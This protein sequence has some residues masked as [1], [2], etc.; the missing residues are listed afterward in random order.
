MASDYDSDGAPIGG[1]PN[2]IPHENRFRSLIPASDESHLRQSYNIPDSVTLHFQEPGQLF[3]AGG[4]VTITERMLMAGF[5]FPFTGIARE[6]LV[7][8][9]VAPSQVKPNGWRYLFASFV[10]WRTKLQKKM[11]IAEFL[12]I[13]WAGFWRDST[14]E[15]TVRKKP[16]FIHL[17]WRYSNNKEWK[18]QIFIVSGQWERVETSTSLDQRVPRHWARMRVGATEA[19]ELTDEQ[20]GNVEAMLAFA[21]ATPAEEASVVLDFNHLMTNE[22]MRN[23]L[24]Y[25]IP[26]SDLPFL[27]VRKGKS[28]KP[29]E[30]PVPATQKGKEKVP[31]GPKKSKEHEKAPKTVKKLLADAQWIGAE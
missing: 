18:E 8:L 26:I 25:D 23:I 17:A 1:G 24:G 30:D 9:G 21:K 22:N 4:D 11:S 29:N 16:S 28:Q 12:T 6:L 5:R 2:L 14:V 3:I 13:Y 7:Q 15:F 27:K 10:L 19:P 31:E 20:A